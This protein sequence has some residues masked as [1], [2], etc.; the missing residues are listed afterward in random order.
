MPNLNKVMLIGNITKD[1][2]IRY[3]PAGDPV[4]NINLAI[5]RTWKNKSGERQK[6]VE[7]ISVVIWN[8]TADVV[9]QYCKKGDP[10]FVEGRIQTRS[11][12]KDGVKH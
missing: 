1:P 4:L 10:L 5:N 7:F 3:T 11:W 9:A 12:E 2:E 6:S 8:K